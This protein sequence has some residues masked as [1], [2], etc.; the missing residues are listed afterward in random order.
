MQSLWLSVTF[1]A[2]LLIS[3]GLKFWLATRQMRHVAGH[4]AAVPAAFTG[5]VSLEAHQ[6]AADYTLVRSRFGLVTLA[7]GT[8]VLLGW[9][10]LGGV[11]VLNTAVRDAVQPRWG[12]LAY[13]L[14]L[15]SAFVL[16]GSLLDAPF[17]LYSTFRIEQAFGFNRTT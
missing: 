7:F 5:M 13:E 16:I 4:R 14:A 12:N 17:E 3:V 8:A 9:T 2:A 1:A 6:K 10:L 11:D 15:L